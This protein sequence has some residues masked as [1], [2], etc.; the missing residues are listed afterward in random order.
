MNFYFPARQTNFSVEA[1]KLLPQ[2]V[3]K[4][5]KPF[6]ILTPGSTQFPEFLVLIR[7]MQDA[8]FCGMNDAANLKVQQEEEKRELRK[9]VQ[10]RKQEGKEEFR[11]ASLVYMQ[12]QSAMFEA[13]AKK[14]AGEKERGED[15]VSSSRS[16]ASCSI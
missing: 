16:T 3:L 15:W 13:L 2:Q 14:A 10:V 11:R 5:T 12:D 4:S 9:K 6:F 8:N 1:M 7:M